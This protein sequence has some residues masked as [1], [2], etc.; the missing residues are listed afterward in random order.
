MNKAIIR[1]LNSALLTFDFGRTL[2]VVF[3]IS[4]PF[5]FGYSGGFEHKR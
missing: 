5:V 4:T 3:I 2:T 1:R